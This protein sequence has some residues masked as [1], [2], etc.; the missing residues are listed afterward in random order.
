ME[1][2]E[3]GGRRSLSG[4]AVNTNCPDGAI[5][6]GDS[7]TVVLESATPAVD[8]PVHLKTGVLLDASFWR[9]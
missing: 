7:R 8:F 5:C 6:A 2:A 1:R 4:F 9:S 3:G